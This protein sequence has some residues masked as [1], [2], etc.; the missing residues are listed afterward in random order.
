MGISFKSNRIS[1]FLMA[2]AILSALFLAACGKSPNRP[3]TN[4]NQNQDLNFE[5]PIVPTVE[6]PSDPELKAQYEAP[7]DQQITINERVYVLNGLKISA[8]ARY[9]SQS[10]QL[11]VSGHVEIKNS[12]GE[13]VAEKSLDLIAKHNGPDQILEIYDVSDSQAPDLMIRGGAMCTGVNLNSEG[14]CSRILIDLIVRYKGT[15]YTEQFEVITPEL[16]RH[17]TGKPTAPSTPPIESEPTGVAEPDD[18]ALLDQ[19]ELQ[20]EGSDHSVNGRYEGVIALLDIE[21]LFG[22]ANPHV[23]PPANPPI[24][25]N[26][27]PTPVPSTPAPAPPNPTPTPLPAPINPIQPVVP[28]QNG[29]P[30]VAQPS[31]API[32]V[33]KPPPAP[34]SPAPTPAPVPPTP[35]PAPTVPV[36]PL[37]TPTQPSPLPVAPTPEPPPRPNPPTPAPMP[38]PTPAPITTP[39]PAPTPPAPTPVAPMPT[40]SPTRPT[41]APTPAPLPTR[42][43]PVTG[44]VAS[45]GTRIVSPPGRDRILANGHVQTPEGIIRP[46]GQSIGFPEAGSLRRSTSLVSVQ[47][48]LAR[49]AFFEVVAPERRKHFATFEMAELLTRVGQYTNQTYNKKLF[50]GNT[51]LV[52]GGKV[53]PHASHQIGID[54]DLA[55]PTT[56][57]G[58][59]FPLVVRMTPRT[60]F[61]RNFSVEKTYDLFKFLFKQTDIGI[62]RIFVDQSIINSLCAHAIAQGE[63]RGAN[64]DF[65]Q[66]MF[67]NLQ[68]VKGHGDHFHVRIKCSKRDPGCRSRVYRKMPACQG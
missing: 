17:N 67:A 42:P 23:A 13:K 8:H 28:P 37:P 36:L 52:N 41:P 40:P 43:D 7:K 19:T 65:V 2:A 66:N 50:V 35:V 44:P 12:A 51:S 27:Q 45:D 25:P 11:G 16:K 1:L 46:V 57:P 49:K 24:A 34:T 31:P 3:D 29:D 47:Q 62:D 4:R 61:P 64:K 32:P 10:K 15:F 14:D 60:Y 22:T 68:H 5:A 21:K 33:P 20:S 30:S 6:L 58:V 63:T 26:P 18:Q 39:V 55:Y 9:N 56:L 38:T 53:S 48:A 59:K 54:V